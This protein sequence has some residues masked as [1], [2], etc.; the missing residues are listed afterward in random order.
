MNPSNYFPHHV[1]ARSDEKVVRV[2]MKHGAAGYG[3]Y[4]MLLERLAANP[5]H[6]EVL[7]YDA[8]SFELRE[9]ID[10]IQSVVENFGLFVITEG[11]DH[12]LYFSQS[13]KDRL[14]EL[15]AKRELRVKAGRKGGMAKAAA[16][17]AQAMLGE[18]SSKSVAMPENESS[19]AISQLNENPSNKSKVKEKEKESVCV[20]HTKEK[21]AN[22]ATHTENFSLSFSK[23]KEAFKE[24]LKPY[25][26]KYG[27]VMLNEFFRYWTSQNSGSQKMWWE[28]E[29][30]WNTAI[31]LEAWS[32]REFKKGYKGNRLLKSD[33]D[34]LKWPHDA[35]GVFIDHGYTYFA[36]ESELAKAGVKFSHYTTP[37]EEKYLER[38]ER[39]QV[40]VGGVL[41][42][43]AE[44]MAKKID[45][46]EQEEKRVQE[47]AAA[48][49]A[50][51]S[52]FERHRELT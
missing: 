45:F 2:R 5:K 15:D 21:A 22:A 23:R 12:R 34:K 37:A 8:L 44:E 40:E 52:F 30:R 31:R 17:K 1:D 19:N 50:M 35:I 36:W 13:L 20:T 47:E 48:N 4:F 14:Y 28:E 10:L 6:E 38:Q 43:L 27:R 42:G 18:E 39:A 25:L 46:R 11:E 24:E 3:V 32:A 29:K 51:R 26:E 16:I 41:G 33:V 9:H 7:D 49:A